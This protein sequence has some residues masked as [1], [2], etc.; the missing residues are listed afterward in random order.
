MAAN[1]YTQGDFEVEL[2]KPYLGGTISAEIHEVGE[3]TPA[4]IIGINDDWVVEVYWT[5]TGSLQPFICGE[6]CV[7]VFL[8]SIGPGREFDLEAARYIP[9]DPCGDG[10]YHA[11]VRV[12]GGTIKTDECAIPYKVV[13]SVTY[14]TECGKPGPIAGFVEGPII[15]FYPEE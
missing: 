15:Q 12:P 9:L 6:W 5:L 14:R 3:D 4:R 8:E 10:R 7:H 2:P 1:D 13:T 11:E